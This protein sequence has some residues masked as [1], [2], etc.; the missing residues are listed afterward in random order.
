MLMEFSV[1]VLANI[2]SALLTDF[3]PSRFSALRK[4]SNHL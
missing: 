4:K 3:L 2:I 1:A